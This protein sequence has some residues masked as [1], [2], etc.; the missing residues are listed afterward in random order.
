MYI[1]DHSTEYKL[2][3]HLSSLSPIFGHEGWDDAAFRLTRTVR[4]EFKM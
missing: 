2:L 3:G 1:L 4:T